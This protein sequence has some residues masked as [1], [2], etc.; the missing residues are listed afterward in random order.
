MLKPIYWSLKEQTQYNKNHLNS[1]HQSNFKVQQCHITF[2]NF[3]AHLK[4]KNREI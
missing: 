1:I 4:E 2:S 3:N